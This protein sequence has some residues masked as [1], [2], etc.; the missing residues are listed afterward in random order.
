ML[1]EELRSRSLSPDELALNIGKINTLLKSEGVLFM[2]G[3]N[4]YSYFADT[5]I[6][7]LKIPE[8]LSSTNEVVSAIRTSYLRNQHIVNL[9]TK[10]L[11]G[12]ITWFSEQLRGVSP[13]VSS[14]QDS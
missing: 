7:N 6:Y 12:F 11:Q 4:S 14:V 1:L 10:S 2:I 5:I 8:F 9:S 13:E 3:A